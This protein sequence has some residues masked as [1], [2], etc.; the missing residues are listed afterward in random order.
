MYD[1][2]WDEV[3]VDIDVIVIVTDLGD[4]MQSMSGKGDEL[5]GFSWDFDQLMRTECRFEK[6]T[7][8]IKV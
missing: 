6:Q 7:S 2:D 3:G 8:E 1:S 5:G 4:D